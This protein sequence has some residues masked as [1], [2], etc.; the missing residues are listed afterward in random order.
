M[1]LLSQ[2]LRVGPREK[3]EN[4]KIF[5]VPIEIRSGNL[6]NIREKYHGLK[7]ISRW[8][9]IKREFCEIGFSYR[10]HHYSHSHVYWKVFP[11]IPV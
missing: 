2:H 10:V 6:P 1:E 4:F 9:V 8:L 7:E 5:N 11:K 3:I